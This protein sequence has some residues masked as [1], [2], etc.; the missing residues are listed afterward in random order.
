MNHHII[1]CD[2]LSLLR[3]NLGYITPFFPFG[4]LFLGPPLPFFLHLSPAAAR[5]RT[6]K[7]NSICP[8]PLG[9]ADL[10]KMR[11]PQSASPLNPKFPYWPNLCPFFPSLSS[12]YPPNYAPDNHPIIACKTFPRVSPFQIPGKK[13]RKKVK[14]HIRIPFL[15][16]HSPPSPPN[17]NTRPSHPTQNSRGKF[18]RFNFIRRTWQPRFSGFAGCIN[19]LGVP[20]AQT[21]K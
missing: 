15:S 6:N 21:P 1:C 11:I 19:P 13:K 18:G 12:I 20:P 16:L 14:N 17:G 8:P 4:Q 3:G 2:F 5:V 7:N 9:P 10:V